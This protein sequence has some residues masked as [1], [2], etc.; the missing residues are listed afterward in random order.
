[1]LGRL[2]IRHNPCAD[3]DPR[4][5]RRPGAPPSVTPG[6][7]RWAGQRPGPLCA[8]ASHPTA[9]SGMAPPHARRPSP[10]PGSRGP[11]QHPA[12]G[13][14]GG[15]GLQFDWTAPLVRWGLQQAAPVALWPPALTPA[16]RHPRP[17]EPCLSPPLFPAPPPPWAP[18]QPD[19]DAARPTRCGG[20]RGEGAGCGA[21]GPGRRRPGIRLEGRGCRHADM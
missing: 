10:G 4:A 8:C 5:G 7:T 1:M 16:T 11:P 9:C 12:P 21:A 18:A 17:A 3:D 2:Q 15:G 19:P 13:N 14:G 20:V 6:G